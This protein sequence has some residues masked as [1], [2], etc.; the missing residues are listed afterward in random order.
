MTQ[1]FL[2]IYFSFFLISLRRDFGYEETNEI[3]DSPLPQNHNLYLHKNGKSLN[4][5]HKT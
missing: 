4:L 3:L 1:V 2:E 5:I